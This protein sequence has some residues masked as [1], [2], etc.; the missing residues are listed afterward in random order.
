MQ[1]RTPRHVNYFV[2]RGFPYPLWWPLFAAVLL[3]TIKV[4]KTITSLFSLQLAQQSLQRRRRNVGID[5]P[6]Y[7]R[8]RTDR[9]PS[10]LK[11][12]RCFPISH[13][14]THES[15]SH[16]LETFPSSNGT[17]GISQTEKTSRP[18]VPL[19]DS[20]TQPLVFTQDS[21]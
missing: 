4:T 5:L 1:K 19:N 12:K 7:L 6:Y 9:D 16:Y 18:I 2:F 21:R 20:K 11:R 15:Q 3:Q 8:T 14:I 10:S 13:E 17:L